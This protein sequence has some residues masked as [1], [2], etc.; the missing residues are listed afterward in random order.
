[1]AGRLPVGIT[2]FAKWTD[3]TWYNVLIMAKNEVSYTVPYID[4]GNSENVLEGE[5]VGDV[6]EIQD[7][8]CIDQFVKIK[9]PMETLIINNHPLTLKRGQHAVTIL[10]IWFN[11]NQNL[12]EDILHNQCT[13]ARKSPL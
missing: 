3:D 1:M 9:D 2:C 12:V 7:S 10:C 11:E 6:G 8:D 4:Y 5:I 13:C